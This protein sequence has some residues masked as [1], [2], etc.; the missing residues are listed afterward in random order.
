SEL[1]DQYVDGSFSP[2]GIEFIERSQRTVSQVTTPGEGVYP[3]EGTSLSAKFA[4]RTEGG[5]LKW[6]RISRSLRPNRENLRSEQSPDI[7]LAPHAE[8]RTL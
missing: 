7:L 5:S 6:L 2:I 1:R 8:P 4:T 3:P